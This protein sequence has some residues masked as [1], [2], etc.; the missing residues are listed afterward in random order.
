MYIPFIPSNLSYLIFGNS[1]RQIAGIVP[2]VVIREVHDDELTITDHPVGNGAPITDH[3]FKNPESVMVEF[4][5]SNNF[6]ALNALLGKSIFSGASNIL[7]I[8]DRLLQLQAS[9]I[10]IQIGTGKRQY[11]DMLIKS[12]STETDI[13]TE[14]ALII[15]AIF[16][17]VYIVSTGELELQPEAQK[18]PKETASMTQGGERQAEA[19]DD[20][21]GVIWV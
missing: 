6:V 8:Y 2:N 7:D 14:N 18:N 20:D 5:W 11:T 16:R 9:R 12:L 19:V 3:A 15:K 10:P 21:E 1:V 4:G 17:K 13:N